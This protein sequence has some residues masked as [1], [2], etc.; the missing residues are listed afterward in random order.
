MKIGDLEMQLLSYADTL[1]SDYGGSVSGQILLLGEAVR[2][3]VSG[4][5]K[6]EP[7]KSLIIHLQT[8]LMNQIPPEMIKTVLGIYGV[9]TTILDRLM[10]PN[11]PLDVDIGT[12][13]YDNY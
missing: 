7:D 9:P 8:S 12:T 13:G 2:Q 5:L 4:E 6:I 3:Y 1:V 10:D 11:D